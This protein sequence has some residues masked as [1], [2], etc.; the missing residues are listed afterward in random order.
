[1]DSRTA[2]HVLTRIAALV[3]LSGGNAFR[4]RAYEGAAQALRAIDTDDLAP[5]VSSGVVAEL[6]GIGPATLSVVRE[7]VETGESS[8]LARLDAE[9]PQGL[10]DV[11]RVQTLGAAKVR[12]LY[13]ALD[14]RSL[15]DL[16]AVARDGRLAK[17]KGFGPK[18]IEKILKGIERLKTTGSTQLLPAALV[19]GGRIVAAL[20]GYP[21]VARAELAGSVRRHVEVARDIDVVAGCTTA[22]ERVAVAVASSPGVRRATPHG[23][24]GVRISYVDDTCL[25]L[26][27]VDDSE[28][29]VAHWRATGSE[30]HIASALAHA[31][32]LGL[33]LDGDSLVDAQGRALPIAD[34]HALYAAKGLSYIP[35]ELREGMAEIDAAARGELPKLIEV[36]DI[37]GVLHCH[38][39]YSDGKA[40]I[41]DMAA[42]AR[43]R[44]WSYLGITDHSQ[45]AF[46]AGGLRREAVLAQHAEI[47]RLNESL[48]GFR[49][50]KG[51]EADILADGRLDYDDDVLDRFD[52]VIGSIHSRFSMG[53]AQM[54]ERVLAALDDP[55]L[56]ILAHPTGRLLLD[57]EPYAIDI[58]AVID[59]AAET[60]AALELNAD[61]KRLDLDWRYLHRARQ[62]GVTVEIGP[63]A[64]STRG[65]DWTALG[66]GMARKGWLEATDVLNARS[67]DDVLSFARRRR[68]GMAPAS[69]KIGS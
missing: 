9:V 63:D 53:Q 37:R 8:Y 2:A 3:E 17:V 52:F 60:N 19:E 55:R 13:E 4:A 41:A 62:K 28:F 14:V 40:S 12:Q 38:S 16:E 5:L 23:R 69:A 22:P 25:D 30:A 67:A 11:L 57:R 54:T 7:L 20:R 46:Y 59:K 50:L 61:P 43:A 15:D 44:G 48:D 29:A 56:T 34:E 39:K 18:G 27:C 68:S 66:V 65:L 35:P 32:K 33:R 6:P 36:A 45:A 26:Y 49:I 1:M 42:A 10:L 64:H 47:D 21:D 24:G 58:D 51:I 31:A